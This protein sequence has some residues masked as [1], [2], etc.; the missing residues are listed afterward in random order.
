MKT[1]QRYITVFITAIIL[2]APSISCFA[3]LDWDGQTG[4]FLNGLAYTAKPGSFEVAAHEVDL[5]GLGSASTYNL[6]A[7][8]NGNVEVGF[9]KYA[10]SV[11]GIQDQSVE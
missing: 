5:G 8:F 10:S 1:T 3:A 9:T 7:G 11:T 6:V 2:I 4:V